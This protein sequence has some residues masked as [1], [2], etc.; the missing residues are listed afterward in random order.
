MGSA[1]PRDA[2]D[3]L[4]FSTRQFD[5]NERFARYSDFYSNGAD[6]I[7]LGSTVSAE[8]EAWRVGELL[9]YA[10][11]ISGLGAERLAP[12]VR[13]NQFDHFTLQLNIAGEF[14]GEGDDGFRVVRP[15]EILVLDMAKPMRSRML[16]V[17]LL[18]LTVPRSVL[19]TARADVDALHGLVIPPEHAGALTRFL[20]PWVDTVTRPLADSHGVDALLTERLGSTLAGM[21][22]A[23]ASAHDPSFYARLDTAQSFIR[24]HLFEETLSPARV[25]RAANLSRATLYRM[26]EDLGGVRKYIQTQRLARLKS[27]L[28][29]PSE[30][31]SV[32]ALAYD[33]GFASEHHASRSFKQEF[34]L[35]PAVFRREVHLSARSAFGD[36]A[37]AL[38]SKM[39]EWYSGATR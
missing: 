9:L 15:G 16:D 21:G 35:P 4:Q 13:R 11:R 17:S 7:A 23:K 22:L 31:Q 18:T 32:A 33:S 25:A 20:S 8:I 29:N 14:H 5:P 2:I 26:F 34:G 1:S 37:S 30:R 12:R 28:S 19:T 27:R 36:Q 6:T 24:D 38:K 3:S 10:R 39:L